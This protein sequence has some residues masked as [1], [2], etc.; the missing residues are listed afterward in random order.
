M[1][2]SVCVCVCIYLFSWSDMSPWMCVPSGCGCVRMN[3][4]V[5]GR[6]SA[7]S[8]GGCWV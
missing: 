5:C 2:A 8:E 4:Y 1:R 6:V 3:V 7:G